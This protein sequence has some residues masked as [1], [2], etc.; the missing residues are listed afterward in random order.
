MKKFAIFCGAR[1]PVPGGYLRTAVRTQCR[2][3]FVLLNLTRTAVANPAQFARGSEVQPLFCTFAE[4]LANL[5]LFSYPDGAENS[6]E[7][8]SAGL[9]V[10]ERHGFLRRE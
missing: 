5:P 6:I 2:V 9:S 4:P 3:A 10:V 8:L 1:Y 7:H